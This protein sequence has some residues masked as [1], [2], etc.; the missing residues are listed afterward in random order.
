MYSTI[1]NHEETFIISIKNFLLIIVR[2]IPILREDCQAG[3]PNELA[4]NDIIIIAVVALIASDFAWFS[5]KTGRKRVH[6]RRYI[7]N[8]S[9]NTLTRREREFSVEEVPDVVLSYDTGAQ[10]RPT[11]RIWSA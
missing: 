10:Y 6:T 8:P 9:E 2:I 3:P 7:I 4:E 1:T 11:A 5:L